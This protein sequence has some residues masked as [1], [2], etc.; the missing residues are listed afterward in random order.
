MPK[1]YDGRRPG[2]ST[3]PGTNP[4]GGNY[5]GPRLGT[6]GGGGGTGHGTGHK[7]GDSPCSMWVPVAVAMLPYALLRMALDAGKERR[8]ERLQGR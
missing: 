1:K 3:G 2:G 8:R 6:G 4:R 7:G 5:N